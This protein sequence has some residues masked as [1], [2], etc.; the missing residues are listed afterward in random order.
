MLS[1]F[2]QEIDYGTPARESAELVELTMDTK[3]VSPKERL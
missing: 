1:P 3:S 2:Q